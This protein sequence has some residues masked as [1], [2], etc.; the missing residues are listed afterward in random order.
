VPDRAAPT[1]T[2]NSISLIDAIGRE[3]N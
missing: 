3:I 2:A 1:I